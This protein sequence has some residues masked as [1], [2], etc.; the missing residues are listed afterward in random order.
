[1][2]RIV[3]WLTAC[4]IVA[5]P[6]EAGTDHRLAAAKARADE[7][8]HALLSED[9]DRVVDLTYPKVVEAMGGRAQMVQ[10][11]TNGMQEMRSHDIR[12]QSVRLQMPS[13]IERGGSEWF[14]I[15]PE[16][17]VLTAPTGR[18]TQPSFLIGISPDDGKTWTF[19]DG[20]NLNPMRLQAVLPAFP[21]S[22]KLPEKQ[23][24]TVERTA[25]AP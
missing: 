25:P 19:I 9:F 1:M 18:V 4:L 17:I 12:Y 15:V 13:A 14:T 22:I 6:V 7:V 11:L 20:G 21:A 5:L 3:A 24:P 10:V 2:M 16:T 8:G 23:P